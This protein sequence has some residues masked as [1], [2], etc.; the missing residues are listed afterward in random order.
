MRNHVIRTIRKIVFWER[1]ESREIKV[2]SRWVHGCRELCLE[3]EI[4]VCPMELLPPPFP[5]P[6]LC[7]NKH[8]KTR[9]WE[10]EHCC[11]S[12]PRTWHVYDYWRQRE[13]GTMMNSIF[14]KIVFHFCLWFASDYLG[15]L[16]VSCDC[17]SD[18]IMGIHV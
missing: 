18:R 11:Y 13:E 8:G 1:R 3:K 12:L 9:N 7:C 17:V 4:R 5:S 10:L 2:T 16:E 6:H 15:V 14:T